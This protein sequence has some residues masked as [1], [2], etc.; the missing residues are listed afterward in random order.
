MTALSADVF[1]SL[2][3][4]S[5][6]KYYPLTDMSTTE[7]DYLTANHFLFKKRDWWVDFD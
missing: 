3:G 4:D 7:Q 2:T 5:K 6:G 1:N